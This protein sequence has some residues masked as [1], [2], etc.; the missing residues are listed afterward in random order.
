MYFLF[1]ILYLFFNVL[2]L[3]LIKV[4]F[5]SVE[6][7]R[8]SLKFFIEILKNF[9]LLTGLFMYICSFLVWLVMIAKS[10]LSF[11]QPIIIGLIYLS[12]ILISFIFLKETINSLKVIGII[13]IGVGIIILIISR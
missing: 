1:L 2:G 12:T 6:E 11:T 5:N 8:F 13:L 4:G 3:Y 7:F 9:K 10:E